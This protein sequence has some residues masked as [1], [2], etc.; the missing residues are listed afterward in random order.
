MLSSVIPSNPGVAGEIPNSASW[1][2][3]SLMVIEAIFVE[4]PR[5]NWLSE[6]S[7]PAPSNVPSTAPLALKAVTTTPKGSA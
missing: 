7:I 1:S 2:G 3:A 6:P 5:T 4:E